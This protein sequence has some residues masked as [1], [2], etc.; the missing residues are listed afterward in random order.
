MLKITPIQS[1][2][3]QK[4]LSEIC[5]IA[6]DEEALAY[7]A[8]DDDTFLGI[9]QFRL[10]DGYGL[11]LNL[12]SAPGIEDFEAMFIMGR[13][14]MNFIDLL[15]LHICKC[16]PDAADKKLL[17]SIGFRPSDDP[18]LLFADMT[19]MFSGECGGHKPQEPKQ[20]NKDGES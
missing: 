4:H 6:F 9:S 12:A 17:Y 7:R 3:E 16:P 20:D 5:G 18:K 11:L 15:G 1:K 19:H 14:T 10:C 8:Y 2:E 13:A